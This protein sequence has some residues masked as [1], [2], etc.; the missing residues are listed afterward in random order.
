MKNSNYK[1]ASLSS[2][3]P[4]PYWLG[5]PSNLGASYEHIIVIRQSGMDYPRAYEGIYG[6]RPTFYLD[7][8]TV[9]P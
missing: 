2:E 8:Y 1:D 3:K 6:V 7:G 9:E 5:I 4:Y